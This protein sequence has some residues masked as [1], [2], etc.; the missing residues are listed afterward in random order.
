M[1][2]EIEQIAV[3]A[4]VAG[5]LALALMGVLSGWALYATAASAAPEKVCFAPEQWANTFAI[6]SYL[7]CGVFGAL[8]VGICACAAGRRSWLIRAVPGR[9]S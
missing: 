2:Q 6:W 7:L 3:V 1:A 5:V 8:F 9:R 4:A